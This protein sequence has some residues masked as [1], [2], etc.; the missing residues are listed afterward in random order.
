VRPD[1]IRDEKLLRAYDELLAED[2]R[3]KRDRYRFEKD[4]HSCLVT[5]ALVR[6]VLSKYA[7]V[8]P[9]AWR[10]VTNEYGRPEI[11]EPQDARW[12]KFNLSHTKGLIAL[13]VA[14]DREVG[15]D[16]EDR[17]RHGR[18]LNV[19]DRYFSAPEVKALRALPENEKLDR[20]FLYWT[21]KESYIKARGM[22]LAIPLSQFSFAIASDISI[23]FDPKLDDDPDSWQFT[24]MSVGRRHA[25]AASMRR[26]AH[27]DMRLVLRE[28][29]PL[30]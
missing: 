3:I 6:T 7:D 2:E 26:G 17:E 21:L 16:V 28:T 15:V 10:F 29:V 11:D 1:E 8:A 9:G 19:A 25:L 13:I 5:R 22:G 18:L 24:A 30:A 23:A 12:L 4:Q 20:F 27:E 14:R